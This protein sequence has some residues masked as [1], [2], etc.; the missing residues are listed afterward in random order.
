LRLTCL[1]GCKKGVS[2]RN[3]SAPPF[4]LSPPPLTPLLPVSPQVE[5]ETG[6]VLLRWARVRVATPWGQ[7]IS[8]L[9]AWEHYTEWQVCHAAFSETRLLYISF[10]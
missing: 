1:S 10:V 3:P 5:E 6:R 2:D 8:S 9:E 4:H 7:R